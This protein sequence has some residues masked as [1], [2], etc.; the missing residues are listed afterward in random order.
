MNVSFCK[1]RIIHAVSFYNLNFH[2]EMYAEYPSIILYIDLCVGVY[3]YV[4]D[5]MKVYMCKFMSS[6][7]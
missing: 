7:L 5:Y 1:N 6:K 4:Y 2:L 3:I